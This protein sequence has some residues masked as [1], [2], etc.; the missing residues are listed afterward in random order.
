MINVTKPFL[1]PFAEVVQS[2]EEIWESGWLSNGGPFHQQLEQ[3][4]AEYLEVPYVSLFCNATIA[5]ITAQQALGIEGEVITTP[6]SFVAT[7]H[8]LHWMRNTPVFV[9]VEEDS[10]SIDPARIEAAIT[11]R[12]AAIMP[13]HCYG[14]TCDVAAIEEIAKRHKIPVIYDAM[15]F[16][17]CYR[18]WW[19]GAKAR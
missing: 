17:W 8:A 1:P 7:T 10:L 18:Q 19:F 12:T 2:L 14:N 11:P 3:D 16:I 6:Y 15:P 5:L 13:L 4:L 9:D